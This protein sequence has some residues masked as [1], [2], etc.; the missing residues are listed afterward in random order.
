MTINIPDV[1]LLPENVVPTPVTLLL[2]LTIEIVPAFVTNMLVGLT[3][4]IG[5]AVLLITTPP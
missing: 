5:S 1:T 4:S 2:P 3:F